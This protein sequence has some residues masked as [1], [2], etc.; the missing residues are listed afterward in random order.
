MTFDEPD[1]ST[2]AP[3]QQRKEQADWTRADDQDV[4]L[5]VIENTVVWSGQETEL[6]E[7]PESAQHAVGVEFLR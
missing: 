3:E 1:S 7:R 5:A 6:P 4:S 2:P